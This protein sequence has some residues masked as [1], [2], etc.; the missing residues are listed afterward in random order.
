MNIY[1]KL[2]STL[3]EMDHEKKPEDYTNASERFDDIFLNGDYIVNE[4]G[5]KIVYHI[6]DDSTYDDTSYDDSYYDDYYYDEYYY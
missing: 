3:N 5:L 2:K 6:Y 4:A 1:Y